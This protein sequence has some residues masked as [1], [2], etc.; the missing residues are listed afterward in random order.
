LRQL[1]RDGAPTVVIDR[2]D[3]RPGGDARAVA[4]SLH[5]LDQIVQI[6][7]ENLAVIAEA[8]VTIGALR[9]ALAT[10]R[11]WCPALR[12]LPD[13]ETVGGAVAGGHGRRSRQY[14]T[15][16]DYLLG[17]RFLCP[18]A[19]LV[20]HG[21]LAIKNATG[22][23]LTR[24]VAGSR[25]LLAVIVEIILRLVPAPRHRLVRRYRTAARDPAW[26]LGNT[27]SRAWSTGEFCDRSKIMP[28]A[29]ELWTRLAGDATELLVEAETDEPDDEWLFRID[30]SCEAAVEA[31]EKAPE[32]YWPPVDPVVSR[33]IRRHAVDPSKV[34]ETVEAIRAA[35]G[36]RYPGCS[37]LGELTGG[38][39]ELLAD[40][41][42]T[43]VPN[44]DGV[45]A[46]R[47]VQAL[48]TGRGVLDIA[49]RLKSAFDPDGLLH[50]SGDVELYEILP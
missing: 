36:A 30:E 6:D 4:V 27:V 31:M 21:G 39:I 7:R 24:C 13:D 34:K 32:W 25:G 37:V 46:S 1:W 43:R 2:A 28:A 48:P 29:V 45:G 41:S 3:D 44:R 15:V 47:E 9:L 40:S 20:R 10:T 16:A 42:A 38:G 35:V 26:L 19:G 49:R 11:L 18:S 33:S 23:N 17:A 50:A 22:Y 5:G 14:G 8:G 12:W